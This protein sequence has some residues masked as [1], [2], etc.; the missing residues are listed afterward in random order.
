[1]LERE[2]H[3]ERRIPLDAVGEK[4]AVLMDGVE[5]LQRELET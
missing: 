5:R 1:M 2:A 3:A 4:F